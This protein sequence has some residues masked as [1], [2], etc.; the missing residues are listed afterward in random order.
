MR[1]ILNISEI[2]PLIKKYPNNGPRY[3]SY[4]TALQFSDNFVG[5]DYQRI[6]LE[7]NQ[8]PVPKPLSLY[9]HLPFCQSLC[10]YCGC[11]KVVTR[12]Q[13]KLE[14][15]LDYLYREMALQGKLY[16]G[17]RLVEQVHI[18]G[19]TPTYFPPELLEELIEMAAQSFHFSPPAKLEMSIEIDPRSV[20][21]EEAAKLVGIGFNRISLGI[22]DMD[23]AVQEAINRV[24][25]LEQITG[26]VEAVRGAGASSVSFDLIY[27]L[28]KQTVDGF[29]STLENVI[30]LKPDRI[31]LYHYAHMPDRIA[32]Q[33]LINDDDLPSSQEKMA[34]FELAHQKLTQAGYQYLGMDHFALP[35][36]SLAK[37]M[38]EGSIQRNFQGYSTHKGCDLIGLGVSA[39]S[40][41]DRCFAQNATD[42]KTYRTC[43]DNGALPIIKGLE[44]QKDDIIRAEVIQKIMCH[45]QINWHDLEIQHDII[46]QQYFYSEIQKLNRFHNDGLIENISGGFQVTE[47]GRYFLRPIAML[48]DNY[49]GNREANGLIAKSDSNQRFSKVF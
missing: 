14:F 43:L 19:G 17:D 5:Q 29:R 49:L 47:K 9:I 11:N 1:I 2:L 44:M 35:E 27:G 39:I 34:I 24:Q 20:T 8:Q 26:I 15:Y 23:I 12:N 7:S 16:A 18:G 22:Q 41:V 45:G 38:N 46:A 33:R 4:P 25:T 6:G 3:T 28:P 48:F 36:D 31:A 37:A 40:H 42:L 21:L 10:Y 13:E 32:S 30:E